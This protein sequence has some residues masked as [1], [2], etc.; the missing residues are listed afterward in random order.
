MQ[1]SENARRARFM[2]ITESFPEDLDEN[3]FNRRRKR[4]ASI[5]ANV[6]FHGHK[7]HVL[8]AACG[9][10]ETAFED[11]HQGFFTSKLLELLRTVG[12]DKLSYADA[13]RRLPS[14][15]G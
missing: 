10:E 14:L 5:A 8:L 4:G 9:P 1:Q 11:K 15:P 12:A 6:R 2:N 3:I 13:I 7:S